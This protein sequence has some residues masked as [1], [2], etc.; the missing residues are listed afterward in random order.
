MTQVHRGRMARM[1]IPARFRTLSRLLYMAYVCRVPAIFGLVVLLAGVFGDQIQE[2]V[3]VYLLDMVD[4]DRESNVLSNLLCIYVGLFLLGWTQLYWS[5]YA[6]AN[7]FPMPLSN[8]FVLR[9][10]LTLFPL[11]LAFLPWLGSA[12]AMSKAGQ[13]L[14]GDGYLLARVLTWVVVFLGGGSIAVYYSK[15]TRE[16]IRFIRDEGGSARAR[17]FAQG[18]WIAVSLGIGLTMFVAA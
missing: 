9:A 2:V 4:G 8:N 7:R 11:A 17:T 13:G 3:R 5:R 15:R 14:N 12:V 10:A 1:R 18:D 16:A 6:L